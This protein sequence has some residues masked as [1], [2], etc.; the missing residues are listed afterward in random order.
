[1]ARA[2]FDFIL[3]D[4]PPLLVVSDPCIVAPKTD[5]L[6]LVVRTNKNSRVALRQ[7]NQLIRQ[8]SLRVF[9]V[10]VNAVQNEPGE[11]SNYSGNYA[12]YLQPTQRPMQPRQMS[13]PV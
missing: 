9:G 4:S 6:L 12:D 7:A 3:V 5:G 13:E 10:V 8:H 11:Y 1:M 2:N